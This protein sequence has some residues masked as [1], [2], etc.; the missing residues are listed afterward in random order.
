MITRK[1]FCVEKQNVLSIICL[2]I[3]VEIA[4]ENSICEIYIINRFILYFIKPESIH[5]HFNEYIYSYMYVYIPIINFV[6]ESLFWN[7]RLLQNISCLMPDLTK[8]ALWHAGSAEQR[9]VPFS[10]YALCKISDALY[11]SRL[12]RPQRT[13][14]INAHLAKRLW[15]VH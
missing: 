8:C 12:Q 2:I 7:S 10:C 4:L 15:L 3:I 13:L 1:E 5:K 9:R 6:R 11:C 14:L